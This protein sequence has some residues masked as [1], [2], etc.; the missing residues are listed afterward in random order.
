MINVLFF[1]AVEYIL[2]KTATF[3]KAYVNGNGLRWVQL[4][5]KNGLL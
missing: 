4:N 1:A 2:S 3:Y 5:Q